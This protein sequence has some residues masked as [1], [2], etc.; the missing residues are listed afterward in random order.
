MILFGFRV[1]EVAA[2]FNEKKDCLW[3]PVIKI[4]KIDRAG[5]RA[6]RISLRGFLQGLSSLVSQ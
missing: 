5:I 2:E 3:V 1:D 6:T 4:M